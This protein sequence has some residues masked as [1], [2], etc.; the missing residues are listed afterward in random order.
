MAR[1]FYV[2]LVLLLL[3]YGIFS[4]TGFDENID[5]GLITGMVTYS[6]GYVLDWSDTHIVTDSDRGPDNLIVSYYDNSA[7]LFWDTSAGDIESAYYTGDTKS[8]T[9][10]ISSDNG[11]TLYI[12]GT[13]I[14]WS[15]KETGSY[16]AR[17]GTLSSAKDA[18]TNKELI[19]DEGSF[20]CWVNL[21]AQCENTAG[22][23][24]TVHLD[25]EWDGGDHSDLW[26][27]LNPADLEDSDYAGIDS[28][29]SPYTHSFDITTAD[30]DLDMSAFVYN[31]IPDTSPI[32]VST[33]RY[34]WLTCSAAT[35]DDEQHSYLNT[36]SEVT[37]PIIRVYNNIK[38]I[39]WIEMRNGKYGLY[40]TK[41]LADDSKEYDNELL[42]D[43]SS[44]FELDAVI[45][46]SDTLYLW[47]NNA[48][49]T[50]LY[51][52]GL[53][54]TSLATESTNEV[55]L[56]SANSV[57]VLDDKIIQVYG[58]SSGTH[59]LYD[60]SVTDLSAISGD[61]SV[62]SNN[63]LAMLLWRSPSNLILYYKLINATETEI[64][65]GTISNSHASG[66]VAV[67]SSSD[68]F[69]LSWIDN[70]DGYDKVYYKYLSVA[71]ELDCDAEVIASCVHLFNN[72]YNVSAIVTW[73]GGED[74][75][76]LLEGN[77]TDPDDAWTYSDDQI[78][79]S[80][81]DTW[82]EVS[83]SGTTPT[84]FN[85]TL[86]A[87]VFIEAAGGGNEVACRSSMPDYWLACKKPRYSETTQDVDY[88]QANIEQKINALETHMN[89]MLDATLDNSTKTAAVLASE[90]LQD[91]VS[92]FRQL[93][94]TSSGNSKMIMR[95]TY[96]GSS[97]ITNFFVFDVVPKLFAMHVTKISVSNSGGSRR[98]VLSDPEYIFY[99]EDVEPGDV[100]VIEYN[101]NH[102]A[103]ATISDFSEPVILTASATDTVTTVTQTTT[104]QTSSSSTSTTVSEDC[105]PGCPDVYLG[106]GECD[107][108]C[109][110][111]DC[112]YDGGDC[113]T[114][115][116]TS[117]S[118]NVGEGDGGLLIILVI[119][120]I[121]VALLVV[122]WKRVMFFI[123][124][125]TA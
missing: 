98:T 97:N 58:D 60:G 47:V 105:A 62:A 81:Y 3:I 120:V 68:G 61:V 54:D 123:K 101:V 45:R 93:N 122:F 102:Y 34:E 75:F 29:I 79:E 42:Y 2:F 109:N 112:N 88:S 86:N 1:G 13:D 104:N 6:N 55:R 87:A 111:A 72:T 107:V 11:R 24:Y 31:D 65:A 32:C 110:N 33:P 92:V 83:D 28:L 18:I 26:G 113:S 89:A 39:F 77:L 10:T 95:I 106:D 99:Y 80:P 66:D 50:Y 15:D 100:M 74:S 48:T 84:D 78:T 117:I 90:N 4:F 9:H 116:T 76:M 37:N 69:Y 41:I 44:S 71:T 38:Y 25:V 51:S 73:H 21:S 64:T 103:N 17:Y 85:I 27:N 8:S 53:T 12:D 14:I 52:L 49:N 96:N 16:K 59:Y 19:S 23:D 63:E 91:D 94:I 67:A 36:S 70:T 121:V 124:Y 125:L 108:A 46:T 118:G 20:Y 5:T 115:T 119:L 7:V 57:A 30:I 56:M 40:Y 35:S 43:S 22:T 114:E 82:F